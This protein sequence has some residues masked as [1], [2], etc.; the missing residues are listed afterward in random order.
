MLAEVISFVPI[1]GVESTLAIG[2]ATVVISIA[3]IGNQITGS[4]GTLV[5]FGW[6]SIPDTPETWTAQSDTSESWTPVADTSET[7]T[8]QSDISESW[9]EIADNSETWTQVTA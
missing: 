9:S 5:G 1:T 8:A 6:G 2:D 4:V 3:I 7:W